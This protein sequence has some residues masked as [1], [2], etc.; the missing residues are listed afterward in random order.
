MLLVLIIAL[1]IFNLSNAAFSELSWAV[2]SGASSLLIQATG[3]I[4]PA[5]FHQMLQ[6]R[7]S[8]GTPVSIVRIGSNEKPYSAIIHL[9]RS[10]GTGFPRKGQQGKQRH[11]CDPY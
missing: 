4:G 8:N 1:T 5:L 6:K 7:L 2:Y 10:L 9:L 3:F 11:K